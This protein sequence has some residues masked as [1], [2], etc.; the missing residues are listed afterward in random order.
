MKMDLIYR[1][2]S[3]GGGEG[4]DR[5]AVLVSEIR[6]RDEDITPKTPRRP[7]GWQAKGNTEDSS[8]NRLFTRRGINVGSVELL[9]SNSASLHF[10]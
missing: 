2:K 9:P 1:N 10:Y 8:S 3:V 7:T 4:L 5:H 6:K